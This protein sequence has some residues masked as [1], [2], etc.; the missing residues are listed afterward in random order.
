MA[1]DDTKFMDAFQSQFSELNDLKGKIEK[2]I[3]IKREFSTNLKSTLISIK[4][5]LKVLEGLIT[6]IK[7]KT[8][9]INSNISDNS[10][11]MD[12]NSSTIQQLT[13]ENNELK[14]NLKMT[15]NEID[16]LKTD[17]T[18]LNQEK[19]TCDSTL[20]SA[21]TELEALKK[22]LHNKGID[23]SAIDNL[24]QRITDLQTKIDTLIQQKK[25]DDVT[26]DNLQKQLE[27]KNTV[28]EQNTEQHD[29]N[30]GAQSD[31][32]TE[33]EKLKKENQGLKEGLRQSTELLKYAKDRLNEFMEI[34]PTEKSVD[35]L[36]QLLIAI[37]DSIKNIET[38]VEAPN[39]SSSS[40]SSYS[41]S[42]SSSSTKD[43]LLI[44]ND[45]HG[46]QV[47]IKLSN[48]KQQLK[49][50]KELQPAIQTIYSNL[51]NKLNAIPKYTTINS[52][53]IQPMMKGSYYSFKNGT[54][55]GGKKTK[56]NK[57]YKRK[58]DKYKTKK[59][60]NIKNQNIKNKTQ[61]GGFT[62]SNVARK[63]R[64]TSSTTRRRP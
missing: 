28:V 9:Q 8:Q 6:N 16:K 26:I 33:N 49:T 40:S 35:E 17:I 15:T 30:V 29:N 43:P 54:L 13:E 20:I 32:T 2:N 46:G 47:K 55:Q 45:G 51:L 53:T 38:I 19:K 44:L 34:D 3:Q 64:R 25:T 58:Y 57:K 11:K 5:R 60:Q 36:N 52:D 21:N 7:S 24:K 23:T 10:T 39:S 42:S 31:L 63:L 59:H 41:S 56:K 18:N 61:K 37:A 12:D 1:N 62:Y 50:K 14:S 22:Q 4:E 48:L 27:L